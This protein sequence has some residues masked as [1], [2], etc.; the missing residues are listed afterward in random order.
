MILANLIGQERYGGR[1]FSERALV[2]GELRRAH[3]Q[4]AGR[5]TLRRFARW[6]QHQGLSVSRTQ[7]QRM[8]YVATVLHTLIPEALRGGLGP[9]DVDEIRRL[10]SAYGVVW[11]SHGGGPQAFTEL[12]RMK[13]R[14]HDAPQWRTGAVREH[15]NAR[16]AQALGLLV[17]QVSGEADMILAGRHVQP[18]EDA[19][20]T[21]DDVRSPVVESNIHAPNA[22]AGH[23]REMVGG[24][25]LSPVTCQA[26]SA[27]PAI[28][29]AIR[30]EVAVPD[31]GDIAAGD[32]ETED[33][34][35]PSVAVHATFDSE[36]AA[37]LDTLP[38]GPLDL[39]SLRARGFTLALK[40][41]NRHSLKESVL[42]SPA[43]GLGFMVEIPGVLLAH[44]EDDPAIEGSQWVWWLL[45]ALSETLVSPERIALLDER[46]RLRGLL[47]ESADIR[48]LF[49]H[50]GYPRLHRLGAFISCSTVSSRTFQDLVLLMENCR[51]LREHFGDEALWQKDTPHHVR[52]PTAPAL[53]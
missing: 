36:V 29:T 26:D 15:L 17:G 41:A 53:R 31:S 5:M 48:R 34:P 12:F 24:P 42:M 22:V 25:L 20:P 23:D 50:V 11:R 13:L 51:R 44:I 27:V 14:E 28:M 45:L 35:R 49:P 33:Q 37:Y 32:T 9:R 7:L 21:A 30:A 46:M 4:E 3:E 10:E 38:A 40:L 18:K 6:L 43:W 2:I 1:S 39:K 19:G 8:D 52:T 16:V 47:Q